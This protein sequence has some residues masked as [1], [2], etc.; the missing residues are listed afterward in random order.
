MEKREDP[1]SGASGNRSRKERVDDGRCLGRGRYE[2]G[3]AVTGGRT[4]TNASE[5]DGKKR[6]SLSSVIQMMPENEG[7]GREL[8][9]V[10]VVVGGE[11]MR[12]VASAKTI[13]EFGEGE[14]VA[15]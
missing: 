3:G 1:V 9:F 11:E 7:E 14:A 4:E 6:L 10:E 2:S 12:G 8:K 13:G 5:L 15:E